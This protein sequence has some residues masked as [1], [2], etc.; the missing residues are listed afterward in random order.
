MQNT[1]ATYL[2]GLDLGTSAAK[3]G[4]FTADGEALAIAS[5]TQCEEW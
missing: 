2:L 3:A 5:S 1:R 4:L